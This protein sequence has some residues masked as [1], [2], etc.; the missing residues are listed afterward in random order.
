MRGL[1]LLGVVLEEIKHFDL[2]PVDVD[3]FVVIVD[4]LEKVLEA[5]EVGEDHVAQ[6]VHEGDFVT[7]ADDHPFLQT[8][9]H[10]LVH[11]SLL[12]RKFGFQ[13]LLLY[14]GVV[15]LGEFGNHD[16]QE[17]HSDRNG[18][19]GV[20]CHMLQLEVRKNDYAEL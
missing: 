15:N 3:L 19:S 20:G 14:Q 8:I 11:V 10:L 13:Y 7:F 4:P 6:L 9:E 1:L 2:H 17:D 12:V 16:D 18:F 5:E